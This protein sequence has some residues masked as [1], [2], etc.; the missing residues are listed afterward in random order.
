MSAGTRP[1]DESIL[2]RVQPVS[3]DASNFVRIDHVTPRPLLVDIHAN[4]RM[5]LYQ[6]PSGARMVQVD[7]REQQRVDVGARE[8]ALGECGVESGERRRGSGIDYRDAGFVF[9]KAGR[10]VSRHAQVMNIG[11][12][13]ALRHSHR[14]HPVIILNSVIVFS[15]PRASI[16]I[17]NQKGGVGKTTTAINLAASLAAASECQRLADRLRSA[18]EYHRR[19]RLPSAI[20]GLQRPFIHAA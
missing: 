10:D 7:V 3:A 15:C 19:P 1:T 9:E 11:Q 14:L 2:S 18:S 6:R 8:S 12:S 20:A 16:A 13:D 4:P 5:A 17:A